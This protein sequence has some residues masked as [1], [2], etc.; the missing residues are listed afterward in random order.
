MSSPAFLLMIWSIGLLH[1]DAVEMTAS[2]GKKAQSLSNLMRSSRGQHS[3]R[4]LHSDEKDGDDHDPD[5]KKSEHTGKHSAK[6]VIS[7]R[8]TSKD[9][10]SSMAVQPNGALKMEH[11]KSARENPQRKQAKHSCVHGADSCMHR[12]SRLRPHKTHRTA[13]FK[14]H[15]ESAEAQTPSSTTVASG[16]PVPANSP[17]APLPTGPITCNLYVDDVLD[18]VYYNGS[19]L[20]IT[21]VTYGQTSCPSGLV[22]TLPALVPGANLTIVAHDSV[23]GTGSSTCAGI[24]VYC[25]AGGTAYAQMNSYGYGYWTVRG[26]VSALLQSPGDWNVIGWGTST[27]TA[28]GLNAIKPGAGVAMWQS[29]YVYVAAQW[30]TPPGVTT[31]TTTTTTVTNAT[32][33]ITKA[34]AGATVPNIIQLVVGLFILINR[35]KQ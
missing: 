27:S 22:V 31:L 20:S 8:R 9:V 19:A 18:G 33:N 1:G 28:C 4:R 29:G 21:G 34:A 32:V 23:P 17:Y 15:E 24:G 16:P 7:A 26:Q 2:S 14:I 12:V 10:D 30:T 5:S 11:A 6:A 3:S 25:T 13:G 35:F